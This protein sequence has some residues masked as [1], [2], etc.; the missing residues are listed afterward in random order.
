[1]RRQSAFSL[2]E[3]PKDSQPICMCVFSPGLVNTYAEESCSLLSAFQEPCWGRRLAGLSICTDFYLVPF[4]SYASSLLT[5]TN[6]PGSRSPVVQP[7]PRL[8]SSF[9][10]R[11]HRSLTVDLREDLQVLK[12]LNEVFFFPPHITTLFPSSKSVLSFSSLFRPHNASGL[13]V[14]W[15]PVYPFQA[16][17]LAF[18]DLLNQLPL[19]VSASHF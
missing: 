19:C 2:Q 3:L 13:A 10:W 8:T 4:F 7:H 17:A 6:T 16:R 14:Y 9:G 15:Q 12:C 11:R 1:M 18:S 5:V